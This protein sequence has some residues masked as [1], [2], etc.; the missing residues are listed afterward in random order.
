M[1][2][3]KKDTFALPNPKSSDGKGTD[4]F[5]VMRLV[6][7][8]VLPQDVYSPSEVARL[9]NISKKRVYYYASRPK[10]PLPLRRWPNGGRGS[11]VLRDELMEWLREFTI[12]Q[13][14]LPSDDENPDLQTP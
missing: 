8:P 2:E 11:F 4:A 6:Q 14:V 3:K 9:L 12:I 7:E 13:G 1:T 10:D 5:F